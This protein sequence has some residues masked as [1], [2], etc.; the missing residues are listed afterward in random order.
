M[1]TSASDVVETVD[2]ELERVTGPGFDSR[3]DRI[4]EVER[5]AD[6]YAGLAQTSMTALAAIA[7][8]VEEMDPEG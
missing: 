8:V 2:I 4:H 3:R 6:Y 1:T 5:Q 7:W